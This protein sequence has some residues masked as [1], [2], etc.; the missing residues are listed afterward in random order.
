MLQ[1][2]VA[3]AARGSPSKQQSSTKSVVHPSLRFSNYLNSV[4]AYDYDC[5]SA[6]AEAET[7]PKRRARPPKQ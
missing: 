7:K 5:R 3:P 2:G 6:K 1:N 4:S